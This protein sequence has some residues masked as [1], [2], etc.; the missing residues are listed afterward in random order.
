MRDIQQHPTCTHH[1]INLLPACVTTAQSV[2]QQCSP[3]LRVYNV[4]LKSIRIGLPGFLT[5]A[6]HRE[7]AHGCRQ[8]LSLWL[9]VL[10][11]SPEVTASH[12][13]LDEETLLCIVRKASVQ[14][15]EGAHIEDAGLQLQD[16]VGCLQ[17]LYST[18]CRQDALQRLYRTPRCF[19][20][21][22]SD[23]LRPLQGDL[24][25]QDDVEFVSACQNYYI[26]STM[27]VI[28]CINNIQHLLTQYIRKVLQRK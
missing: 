13:N 23:V 9:Q 27:I 4:L 12:V 6:R 25:T 16:V 1:P 28:A 22:P 20:K 24:S 8:Q 21:S 15:A 17:Q 18:A 19:L 11:G 14:A 2:E 7:A 10:Q 26:S 5:C 3:V